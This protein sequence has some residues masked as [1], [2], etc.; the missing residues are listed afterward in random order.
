MSKTAIPA[1]PLRSSLSSPPPPAT[2]IKHQFGAS[3]LFIYY[4][5]QVDP[6][7]VT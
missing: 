3:S 1:P 4:E 2:E 7:S 5:K 6:S